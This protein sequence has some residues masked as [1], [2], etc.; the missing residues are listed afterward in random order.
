MGKTHSGFIRKKDPVY[1]IWLSM[2]DRCRNPN[3]TGYDRY[4]GRG[5]RVCDRWDSFMAFKIDV[6]TRPTPKHTLDRINNDG[7]YE[8][9]NVRWATMAEQRRN[10][11]DSRR[12]EISG[13]TQ[14]ME[15]WAAEY[16]ISVPTLIKRLRR[17]MP[18][19]DA[20]STPSRRA[21]GRPSPAN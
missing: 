20:L 19:L 15:D 8:P 3:A 18:I 11:R 7:N 9:G 16:G 10:A 1:H 14:N 12:F 17:G 13:R 2:R 21:S 4:G 5:I 6:G